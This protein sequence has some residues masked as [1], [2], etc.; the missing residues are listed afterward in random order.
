M[1]RFEPVE[2]VA[3]TREAGC[4]DDAADRDRTA[5]IA[6]E[7][8]SRSAVGGA[9][10]DAAIAT[11]AHEQFRCGSVRARIAGDAERTADRNREEQRA[12]CRQR[13]RNHE[14]RVVADGAQRFDRH[15]FA[16]DADR[17]GARGVG[18]R[19]NVQLEM[20]RCRLERRIARQIERHARRHA[21]TGHAVAVAEFVERHVDG[22]SAH[23]RGRHGAREREGRAA[24]GNARDGRVHDADPS[25]SNT[26]KSGSRYRS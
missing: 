1:P 8:L 11:D 9:H 3:H 18:G 14:L 21:G 17:D 20:Q 23:R 5:I 12:R 22:G 2:P 16:V 24:G 6:E 25:R 4:I 7:R 10:R 26:M 19:C 13:E 15:R